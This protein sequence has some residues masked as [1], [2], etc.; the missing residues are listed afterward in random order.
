MTIVA[1]NPAVVGQDKVERRDRKADKSI[2]VTGKIIDESIA[3]MKLKVGGVKDEVI[4]AADIQ[5]VYYDDMPPTLKQ[6]YYTLFVAEETEK[7]FAKLLKDYTDFNAKALVSNDVKPPVKRYLEFRVAMLRVAAGD[8]NAQGALETFTIAHKASWEYAFAARALAR[9][10]LEKEDYQNATKL[11]SE[12]SANTLVPAEIKQEAESLLIDAMFQDGKTVEVQAKLAAAI[13]DTK[14]PPAQRDRYKVY[15]IGAEAK[16]GDGKLEDTVKKLEK[17]IAENADPSIR[18]VAYN[19]MGDIYREK[20]MPRDA[21]WAYLWVDV[22]Y[23]QDKGEHLKAMTRLLK[24]FD[25]EKDVE[26]QQIYREK[27]ARTK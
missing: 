23:S 14:T 9:L 21:M 8:A 17:V 15:L 4:P 16:A 24:Y 2:I 18:A 3:G 5:R 13:A 22:V 1:V 6:S 25:E 12:L 26:K 11:L 10:L 7:N 27:I 19:I 20:K